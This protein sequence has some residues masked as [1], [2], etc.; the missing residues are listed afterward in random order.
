MKK[1]TPLSCIVAWW[2]SLYLVDRLLLVFMTI[3]LIQSAHSL[4]SCEQAMQNSATLNAVIRTAAASIFGYFISAG[5]QGRS[6]QDD[7]VENTAI[8]VSTETETDG[9]ARVKVTVDRSEGLINQRLRQ[10]II[11]VALIGIFSLLILV[12]ACNNTTTAPDAVAALSQLRD[13]VS[14]SIGFLI[15]HA[16]AVRNER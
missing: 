5:F 2:R 8:G 15:A 16:G 6:N 9:E 12:A 13:L 3:L 11:I 4:F 7:S 10:Q 14:G 1:D